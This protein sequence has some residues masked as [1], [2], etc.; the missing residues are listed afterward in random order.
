[1]NTQSDPASSSRTQKSNVLLNRPVKNMT[2]LA[3]GL[4]AFSAVL[5]LGTSETKGTIIAYWDQ[6]SN[7]LP[8]GGFGFL[9]EP[10]VFP[11]AA[12]VGSGSITFGGGILS[13]TTINNNGDEIY[14]WLPSLAGSNLNAP[15]GV[16]TGGSLSI[17]G[18]TLSGGVPSNNGAYFDFSFSMASHQLVEVS[19]A[20]RGTST[21]FSSQTWLWSTDGSD[22]TAFGTVGGLTTSFVTKTLAPISELAF[23]ETAYLRV[24]FDGATAAT[25]NNRLDNITLTAIPEPS[26]YAFL[27]GLSAMA[28][29]VTRR[30]LARR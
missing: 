9:A 10:S 13:E 15:D 2:A 8:G 19:Y 7:S 30:R 12:D 28:L 11:Q 5:M 25:G 29:I 3:S 14:T 4:L 6:N 21:G 20:T 16:E 24:V 27:F 1:M 17:Q 26:T 23:A 22:F 18:G